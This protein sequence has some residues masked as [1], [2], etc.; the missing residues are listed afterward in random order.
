MLFASEDD[1]WIPISE[2]QFIHQQLNCEYHEFKDQGHFGGDYFKPDFP[3]LTLSI[4]NK[5]QK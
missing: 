2:P 3:E 1:P 4:L 5:V